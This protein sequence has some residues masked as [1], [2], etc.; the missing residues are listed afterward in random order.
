MKTTFKHLVDGTVFTRKT[1]R[2]YTHVVLTKVDVEASVQYIQ[3]NYARW[4]I[5]AK[6]DSEFSWD[7]QNYN[8]TRAVGD[9][10]FFGHSSVG[11]NNKDEAEQFWAKF[12]TLTRDEYIA[13]QMQ[14]ERD[15][16]AAKIEKLQ[17]TDHKWVVESWSGSLSN[18]QKAA[19]KFTLDHTRVEAINNGV[20]A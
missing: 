13:Q 7:Y 9:V 10:S 16:L 20:A 18:A 2:A 17:M 4:I 11:Q 3:K 1:A 15:R 6:K 8:L 12:G 5:Q 19:A 14:Q